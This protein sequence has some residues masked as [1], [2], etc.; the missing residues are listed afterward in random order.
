MVI[1][2]QE[3]PGC[4]EEIYPEVKILES[5]PHYA[6]V[7][8]PICER[9]LGFMPKPKNE[10]KN[11][12]RPSCPSA[13]DLDIH[14]CQICLRASP[15]LGKGWL[16]VHHIDDDPTHNDRMNLLVVCI[17]CHKLIHWTR[18]YLYSHFGG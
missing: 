16:C 7:Q 4:H 6:K 1:E 3:C 11:A 14:H 9:G 5:G 15:E 8:C 2:Y 18:T 12:K 13:V 10:D 17:A